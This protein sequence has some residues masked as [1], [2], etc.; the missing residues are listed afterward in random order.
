MA[1]NVITVRVDGLTEAK[2]SLASLP[3]AF[4]E[5]AAEAIDEGSEIIWREAL[6]RV[7]Y[8]EGDLY[9]SIQR[10][11]REDG[12]QAAVGSDQL[13][14]RFVEFGTWK[15]PEQ[16]W[17]YPAFRVGVRHIRR[18]MK[19]WAKKAGQKVRMRTRRGKKAN[20]GGTG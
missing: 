10:N 4:R 16:P 8:D 19:E 6:R 17:L 7:P 18:S 9:R 5:A 2:R 11:V 14:A 15:D 1:A 3:E 20:S 13:H 12:L